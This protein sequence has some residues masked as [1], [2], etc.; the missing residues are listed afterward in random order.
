MDIS[1]RTEPLGHGTADGSPQRQRRTE[2]FWE[3]CTDIG[4]HVR[5]I[6][7]V[8]VVISNVQM[9]QRQPP[10]TVGNADYCYF[11]QAKCCNKGFRPPQRI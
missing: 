7:V 11:Q 2:S 9:Q 8:V 5:F 6:I 1:R 3:H 4:K 10:R